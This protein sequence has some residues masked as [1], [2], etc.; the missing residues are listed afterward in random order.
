MATTGIAMQGLSAAIV[1]TAIDKIGKMITDAEG[2]MQ[3]KIGRPSPRSSMASRAN[4]R[5]PRLSTATAYRP[6]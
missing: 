6:C 2:R 3:S 5:S 4:P 1:Y